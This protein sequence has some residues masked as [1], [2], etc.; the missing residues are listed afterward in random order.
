MQPPGENSP[1]GG[2]QGLIG[3]LKFSHQAESLPSALALRRKGHS[4]VTE[5]LEQEAKLIRER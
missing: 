3:P 1:G 2:A 5:A 4:W